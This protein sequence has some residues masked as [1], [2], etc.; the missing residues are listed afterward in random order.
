MSP[1][2]AGGFFTTKSPGNP[3]RSLLGARLWCEPFFLLCQPSLSRDCKGEVKGNCG[4]LKP[5]LTRKGKVAG[6]GM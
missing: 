3:R 4:R 1:A 2:L 6:A 5:L